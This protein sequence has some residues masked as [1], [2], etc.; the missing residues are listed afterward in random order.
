M[1][2]H[3]NLDRVLAAIA[4]ACHSVGRKP[5]SVTLVAVTKGVPI[6]K[7]AAAYEAGHRDFGESRLKEAL[8]KLAA[9]PGEARWHFIGKLQS[10]K[11]RRAAETFDFLHTLESDAQLAEIAKQER[12]ID[13]AIQVNV[14]NEP[15]KAGISPERLDEFV[16]VC[17]NCR[18]VRLRGLM[19]IGPMLAPS[20]LR[21]YF[22]RL[23]EMLAEVP[24]GDV[25]SMGMSGDFVEAI[26]EGATHVRVGSAIFGDR[27]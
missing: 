7:V 8:P 10:N 1:S 26:Q 3:E 22:K 21:P 5:E 24:G 19:T 2:V 11:A 23:K 16:Q 12:T 25:L 9:L 4:D 17:L 6:E 20:E 15:Q 27:T 18:R 13:A 14:A